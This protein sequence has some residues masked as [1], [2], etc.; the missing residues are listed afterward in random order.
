VLKAESADAL[1][2]ALDQV[3]RGERYI[4]PSLAEQL[5][6]ASSERGGAADV[7]HVLSEREHEV[8]RLAADCQE[9]QEIARELC[10]A[11]KTVDTH[12]NRIN[13]KLGLRNRAALVRL[14]ARFGLVHAVRSSRESQ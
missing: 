1:L 10:L 12:L 7:L 6:M 11:R 13:H 2:E 9:P 4:P 8:F 3:G 14:A 5:S